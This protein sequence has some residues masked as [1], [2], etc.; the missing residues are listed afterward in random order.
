MFLC[1][2]VLLHYVVDLLIK[3]ALSCISMD[4][5][6]ALKSGCGIASHQILEVLNSNPDIN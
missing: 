2:V 3:Q 1:S 6:I 4:T 5:A